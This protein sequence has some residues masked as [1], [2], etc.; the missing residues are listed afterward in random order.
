MDIK[1]FSTN[2]AP[3]AEQLFSMSFEEDH[4][5]ELLKRHRYDFAYSAFSSE[6]LAAV[7]FGWRSRFHPNCT[8][9]KAVSNPLI[10]D[11]QLF[12]CLLA[13]VEQQEK[14]RY[15]LQTTIWETAAALKSVYEKN[16]FFEIRRTSMPALSLGND[17]LEFPLNTEHDGQVIQCISDLAKEGRDQ[18]VSL[19]KRIYE[20]THE[21]N[22]PA[23]QSTDEW[24]PLVFAEDMIPEGSFVSTDRKTGQVIAYS[25]LHE[26]GKDGVHE[27]GWCGCNKKTELAVLPKLVQQQLHYSVS[28]QIHT[29]EGEFDTT[30]PYAMEILK[31]FPFMPC[32]ALITYQKK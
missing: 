22:P 6:K 8:Y 27:L 16:G 28:Q 15:P 7:M 23:D 11:E 31:R 32:P 5:L 13:E 9:F 10:A 26:S 1:P 20:E 19:V 14:F 18:L 21:V 29:I 3:H 2:D 25:F 24:E 30:D 12:E 17:L 4:L